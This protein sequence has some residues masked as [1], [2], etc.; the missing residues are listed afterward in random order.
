MTAN[1]L[2]RPSK[3]RH[4]QSLIA[5][6]GGSSLSCSFDRYIPPTFE[7]ETPRQIAS[8]ESMSSLF[9]FRHPAMMKVLREEGEGFVQAGKQKIKGVE[10]LL[11]N[12]LNTQITQKVFPTLDDSVATPSRDLDKSK[13]TD[14]YG[15]YLSKEQQEIWQSV[16]LEQLNQ[17]M[18]QAEAF[19]KI[20]QGKI[21]IAMDQLVEKGIPNNRRE[22]Y[23]SLF[24]N[25]PSMLKYY[26]N[27]YKRLLDESKEVTYDSFKDIEKDVNRTFNCVHDPAFGKSLRN[28]LVAYSIRNTT[29]GYCQSMNMVAGGL[30][31]IMKDEQEVFWALVHIVE[32]LCSL[33]Y[34]RDGLIGVFAD[35]CVLDH[36][37]DKF[38]P[39]LTP[40]FKDLQLGNVLSCQW[41]LPIFITLMP[42]NAVFR[43]W[44]VFFSR[45]PSVLIETALAILKKYKSELL[46]MNDLASVL[47]MLNN[48]LLLIFQYEDLLEMNIPH[49]SMA[50]IKILRRKYQHERIEQQKSKQR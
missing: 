32:S 49:I 46:A 12:D 9:A 6:N 1:P 4:F 30:L 20:K 19:Q 48:K 26:P 28:V 8:R 33:Y 45:G 41:F 40:L 42:C 31:I 5:S 7:I 47:N 38:L 24:L 27:E 2:D 34:V 10:R 17:M 14:V 44:D 39:E 50:E 16:Q 23:W 35:G 22:Y 36:Y 11:L 3:K 15:F 43:I 25:V 21:G 29:V 37:V 13:A 18:K